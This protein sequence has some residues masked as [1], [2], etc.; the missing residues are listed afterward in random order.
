MGVIVCSPFKPAPLK[1]QCCFHKLTFSLL[2]TRNPLR[3]DPMRRIENP[4]SPDAPPPRRSDM[5]SLQAL[6]DSAGLRRPH[7]EKP[8][9]C[10]PGGD[11]GALFG[12]AVQKKTHPKEVLLGKSKGCFGN[13]MQQQKNEPSSAGSLWI[14]AFARIVKGV[15]TSQARHPVHLGLD[16]REHACATAT[17]RHWPKQVSSST[18]CN[19]FPQAPSHSCV[20]Q[21]R[22][23][24]TP[25]KQMACF[26]LGLLDSQLKTGTPKPLFD[27]FSPLALVSRKHSVY[28]KLRFTACGHMAKLTA[29]VMSGQPPP[30]FQRRLVCS[31]V[32]RR[33]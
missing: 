33:V 31:R 18:D 28:A 20:H 3:N 11:M 27:L 5:R 26:A 19:S 13:K 23:G 10:L 32:S 21:T 12:G 14:H 17:M 24:E 16:L 7:W 30:L 4:F 22:I 29:R 8:C 2:N 1:N 25:R 6:R 9:P 15:F